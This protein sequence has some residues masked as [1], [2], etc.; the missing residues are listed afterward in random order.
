MEK[1]CANL[2]SSVEDAQAQLSTIE[3][4]INVIC[5][6]LDGANL[7]PYD[8]DAVDILPT[9]IL[10]AR[11]ARAFLDEARDYLYAKARAEK[12]AEKL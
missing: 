3:S 9:V 1:S 6:I 5:G 10:Y 7:A 12:E 11:K 8:R 4:I 2:A